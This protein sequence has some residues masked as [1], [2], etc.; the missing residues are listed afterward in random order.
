MGNQRRIRRRSTPIKKLEDQCDRLFRQYI[1]LRDHNLCYCGKPADDRP[2]QCGHLIT[3]AAK[4]VRWLP[5]NAHACHAGCNY[6]HEFRPEIYTSWFLQTHGKDTY[7]MLVQMSHRPVKNTVETL[8]STA[9][10]LARAIEGLT[11]Q[12]S[13]RSAT[14]TEKN[15]TKKGMNGSSAGSA[16][17]TDGSGTAGEG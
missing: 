7:D 14:E 15:T 3:R 6:L 4:S 9:L 8:T 11:C 1:L 12:P 5:L 2:M 10:A 13:A 16:T 17:E